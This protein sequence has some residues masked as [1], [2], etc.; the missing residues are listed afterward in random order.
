MS[1]LKDFTPLIFALVATL[2]F[3][4]FYKVNYH[5]KGDKK[6]RTIIIVVS[7]LVLLAFIGLYFL[8]K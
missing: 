8:L 3:Y 1:I 7:I 6:S 4:L 5:K 2:V